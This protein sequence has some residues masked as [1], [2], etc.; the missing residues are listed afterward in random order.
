MGTLRTAG[1]AD[2]WLF[3]SNGLVGF[4]CWDDG[5]TSCLNLNTVYNLSAVPA[6]T[7][8]YC[9]PSVGTCLWGTNEPATLA[10][11][12]NV[13]LVTTSTPSTT[14][15]SVALSSAAKNYVCEYDFP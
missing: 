13:Y 12:T 11:A 14:S 5:T 4:Y 8:T 10:G 3:S 1:V 6:P 9:T 2:A 7:N 15:V